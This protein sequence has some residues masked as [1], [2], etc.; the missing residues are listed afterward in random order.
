MRL[1]YT[2][3]GNET[4]MEGVKSLLRVY[5]ESQKAM[6]LRESERG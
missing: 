2:L 5:V 4:H 6:N 3:K 1:V